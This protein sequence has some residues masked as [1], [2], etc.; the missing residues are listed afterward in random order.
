MCTSVTST[1]SKVKVTELVK[2]RK[3]HFSRSVSSA[4]LAWSSKLMVDHDSTGLSLQLVGARF[5]FP[6]KKAIT[7]VQTLRNVDITRIS[8]DYIS[9]LL[10]ATVTCSGVLVVLYVLR[11]L[12][13]SQPDPRSRSRS[14]TFWTSSICTFVRWHHRNSLPFISAL[15]EAKACDC[16]CMWAAT[17]RACW[18]WCLSAPL[19]GLSGYRPDA[20]PDAQPTVSKH[21]RQASLR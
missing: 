8:N 14:L 15:A 16:D 18:R 3:L 19:W 17:S 12:M 9:L 13:W 4:I 7:W 11:M 5:E 20:V 2:L 6:S 10:E 1:R 21:W